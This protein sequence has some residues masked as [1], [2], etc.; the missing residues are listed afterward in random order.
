MLAVVAFGLVVLTRGGDPEPAAT[1][2]GF[3]GLSDP[4]AQLPIPLDSPSPSV[5]PTPVDSIAIERSSVPD[6]G[7]DLSAEGTIDWVHWGE[8]GTYALE[9]NANG[10]FAILEGTPGADRRRHTESPE[11]YRWTGGSPL[12]T[13]KGVTSGV[14]ACDDGGGFTL[15][16]P[17]GTRDSTLRL[18][19]GVL[20]GRGKLQVSLS[21]GGKAVTDSWEQ[22]GDS[23]KTAAY[24]VSYTASGTGKISL[25]WI[26]EESFDGDCG[27][28]SLQAATL[29]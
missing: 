12:A 25:K 27:G 8:Q 2:P 29:R 16:A 1:A 22:T 21:T 5:S 20:A 10:G 14:Q 11:R 18:Y 17:A 23:M 13:G 28:V 19:V 7:V 15:S 9:R 24:T 3:D 6:E 26:T 4:V